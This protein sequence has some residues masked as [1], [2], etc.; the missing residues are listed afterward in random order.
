MT[1]SLVQ[2]PGPGC[3]VEFMQGNQPM[4]GFV[5]GEKSGRMHVFTQTGRETLVPAARLLP[6]SGPVYEGVTTRSGMEDAVRR[7]AE[8]R[9]SLEAGV[10]ALVLWELA[11]GE[12][13]AAGAEWFAELTAQEPDVDT[14]AAV[15]R[16]LLGRKTHFKFQPPSFA[17]YSAEEVER[18]MGEAE[19]QR[20]AEQLVTAGRDF[21]KTLWNLPAGQTPPRLGDDATENRLRQILLARIRDPEDR[22]SEA[23]WRELRK[24]LPE[25]PHLALLIARKWGLVPPHYNYLLDQ[26][27]FA[28][29]DGWADEHAAETARQA[30]AVAALSE[31]D[32]ADADYVSIDSATTRDIDDAFSIR[33]APG[34]IRLS[35]ALACPAL[36]WEF[37]GELDR[38]VRDRATSIYLPE[39]AAYMMPEA[40]ATDIYSLVAKKVRPALVAEFLL[41]ENGAV[42]EKDIRFAPVRLSA[43]VTYE[44]AEEAIA[45]DAEE[46]GRYGL[47]HA[48]ARALRERRIERGAVVIQRPE[49]EISLTEEKND[50]QVEVAEKKETPGSQLLVSEFMILANE[51]AALWAREKGIALLHRTQDVALPRELAGIWSEPLDIFRTVKQMGPSL[52]EAAP[53][54]HRALGLE[55]Y[56]PSTSPLRR[57]P[58]LINS[59]QIHAFLTR[60]QALWDAE[61]LAAMLPRLTARL[62]AASQ[63]QRFRPRYWKLLHV[64]QT[65]KKFWHAVAVEECG[66][67]IN[68]S[69]PELQIFVRAPKDLCG[70]KFIAGQPCMLRFG[71][72]DPLSNEIRVAEAL[73]E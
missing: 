17:I 42:L 65:P 72:A 11:Q 21:V 58:D 18:R 62:E 41:A 53:K 39:G 13:D 6:W 16:A 60:G 40:L 52:L 34:G 55:A 45:E 5:A 9:N 70:E 27:G 57:Y 46:T 30:E 68:F 10:D 23:V 71:K 20:V 49:P 38:A 44:A 33:R 22:E 19:R 48:V 4:V 69:V 15:G 32:A 28:W 64:K 43:N 31:P 35:V 47:A 1:S 50:V 37:G 36:A 67:L 3:I 73:A 7:H 2:H 8:L 63:V 61:E 25:N 14:V 12:V 66:N 29:G 59:A 56:A 26:A 51:A 54:P 24:G